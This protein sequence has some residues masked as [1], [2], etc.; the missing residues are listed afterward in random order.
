MSEYSLDEAEDFVLKKQIKKNAKAIQVAS[1]AIA[2]FPEARIAVG[3]CVA[4]PVITLPSIFVTACVVKFV[5][6][7]IKQN[8]TK[9]KQKLDN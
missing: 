1:T 3:L 8:K 2:T 9:T 4:N 7:K 6:N 5:T